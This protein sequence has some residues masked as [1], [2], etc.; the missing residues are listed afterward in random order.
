MNCFNNNQIQY[1][2][3][4]E[5]S[6]K[7]LLLFESHINTCNSCKQKV[8]EQKENKDYILKQ[9]ESIRIQQ[10]HTE[11][12]IP[13]FNKKSNL[14]VV[15]RLIYIVSAASLIFIAYL[16][17]KPNTETQRI[18]IQSNNNFEFD[19]NSSITNQDFEINITNENGETISY[20]IK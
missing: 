1:Y 6:K 14:I 20:Y 18:L 8:I 9:F 10:Y 16:F 5:L 17:T 2:I 11:V 12:G 13:K 4:G 19:A 15:K 3:D 7:D